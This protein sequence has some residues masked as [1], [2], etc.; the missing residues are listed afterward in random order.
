MIDKQVY[1]RHPARSEITPADTVVRLS[2]IIR[3]V[4]CMLAEDQV[5]WRFV[6]G[7]EKFK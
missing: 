6:P 7:M 1:A 3:T 2:A 5:I 4:E